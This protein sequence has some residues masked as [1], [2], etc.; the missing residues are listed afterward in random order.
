MVSTFVPN[1]T[2]RRVVLAGTE[3]VRGTA[4]VP[5]YRWRG[6]LEIERERAVQRAPEATGT[7]DRLVTPNLGLP[8]FTGTYGEQLTYQSLGQHAR[9][10]L[11]AGDA[12]AADTGATVA[13]TR[14][15]VPADT[16]DSATLEYGFPGLGFR[17]VGVL[18]NEGTITWDFD[19]ADGVWKF[20]STLLPA[21]KDDLPGTATYTATGATA[22]TLTVTGAA[23]TVDAHAGAWVTI[24][25]GTAYGQ[26]RQVVSNTI[27]T[28][29]LSTAF[30]PV[31]VI[32]DAFRL[33][34]LFTA[35]IANADEVKIA[36]PG[37]KVYIDPAGGT[38][39]T[40]QILNR[41]ISGNLTVANALAPKWFL[42]NI[43][44]PSN[45]MDEGD[46]II[47]GQL[48]MEFDRRDEYEQLANLDEVMIRIE[49]EGP[50]I[51]AT[52]GSTY[53]ARIDVARAYWT[54][55]TPGTRQNNITATFAFDAYVPAS[56]PILEIT[57]V[58]PQATLY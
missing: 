24:T 32:G 55:Y 58:T 9:Y 46:R 34:G 50:V 36:T 26:Q 41:M 18:H 7:R 48:Q 6:E 30:N 27:D 29:T 15:I 33:E 17:S 35:G 40:R 54:N 19:D 1:S 57:T 47:S 21:S 4:V 12:P 45:K 5:D 10:W 56:D 25:D 13:Y 28:L 51:D 16:I 38:I 43:D 20:S 22:T 3:A 31:P 14:T 53:L 44:N 11:E 39:G 8:S 23:W 37:T 2:S 52:E 49:K 42:E